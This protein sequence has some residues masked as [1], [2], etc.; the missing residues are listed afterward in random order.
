MILK[1]QC[2]FN[3]INLYIDGARVDKGLQKRQEIVFSETLLRL[4]SSLFL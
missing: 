1:K 3:I 4:F 2:L